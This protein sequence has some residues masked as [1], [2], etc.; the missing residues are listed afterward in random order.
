MLTREAWNAL[1]KILEEPPPRVVFVFATTE[2][3]KIAQTAAPV[4]SRLQRFDLKRIAPAEIRTRL[5]DILTAEGVTAAPEA[6]AMIARAADGSMRDALSLADQVLALGDGTIDA[7]RVRDALGLVAEDEFI[8]L[9]D[10]IAARDPAAIFATVA[11]LA[12]QGIDFGALLTGFAEMLRAQLEIVL[13][14]EAADLSDTARAALRQRAGA[15]AAA[16]LLRMLNA[17]GELEQRFR[18]SGQQQLLL[19]ALLVR[20]ALMD[21][22]VE[23]E[24]VL[25]GLGGN[26]PGERAARTAGP[27]PRTGVRRDASAAPADASVRQEAAAPAADDRRPALAPPAARAATVPPLADAPAESGAGAAVRA[28]L[29][30]NHLAEHWD[31]VIDR[32]R[33][34]GKIVLA[35]ALV[36]TL[37]V[38][39]SADGDVTLQIDAQQEG[40]EPAIEAHAPDLVKAL[41]ELFAGVTRVRLRARSGGA[42]VAGPPRRLTEEAIRAQRVSSLR[43]RDPVLDAA[44]DALDLEL[45]D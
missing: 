29:D 12:D 13:G 41:G 24:E 45:L 20:F 1:L 33:R 21:R 2:P 34:G 40:L 37:P 36:H 31:E 43:K 30:L 23:I 18:K 22:A 5:G 8:A 16:D 38:A 10:R 11:R 3:Q 7:G 28:P 39:V 35:S 42:A 9:L 14:G 17:I 19:E 4:L 27:S 6:I 26:G 25:R 32:V 15:F 44:I